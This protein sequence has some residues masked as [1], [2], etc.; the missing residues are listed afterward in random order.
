[1]AGFG[2]V[3]SIQK[4]QSLYSRI[5]LQENAFF[6]EIV[7]RN[8]I[9]SDKNTRSQCRRPQSNSFFYKY[10]FV[11]LFSVCKIN[12]SPN[13]ARRRVSYHKSESNRCFATVE[14]EVK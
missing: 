8:M 7:S 4:P 6:K 1:M 13:A 12:I 14:V 2:H 5:E 10:L 3:R 9:V 11:W